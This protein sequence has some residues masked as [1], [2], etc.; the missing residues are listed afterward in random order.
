MYVCSSKE[1]S[2]INCI[3]S[4]IKSGQKPFIRNDIHM[5]QK[6]QYKSLIKV[7]KTYTFI[8][9]T[10]DVTFGRIMIVVRKIIMEV[11]MKFTV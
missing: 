3:E 2:F 5:V 8:S 7:K 6:K 11:S 9:I 10:W 1:K 4:Y